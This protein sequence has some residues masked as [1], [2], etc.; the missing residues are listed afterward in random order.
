MS[1]VN[2]PINSAQQ[3]TEEKN[4]D[5]RKRYLTFSSVLLETLAELYFH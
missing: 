1:L 4:R 3:T 2:K 5:C